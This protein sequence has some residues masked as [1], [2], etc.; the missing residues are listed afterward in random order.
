MTRYRKQVSSH[1]RMT[2][3]RHLAKGIDAE[4]LLWTPF[5]IVGVRA[6]R[7]FGVQTGDAPRT[8]LV[9]TPVTRARTWRRSPMPS[10]AM[11]LRLRRTFGSG[12]SKGEQGLE[13]LKEDLLRPGCS[14]GV[15]PM[16]GQR[17]GT[18]DR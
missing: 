10:S 1:E 15:K 11:R 7:S 17:R 13:D 14:H 4:V 18:G 2:C 9:G 6:R 16:R 8:P 12:I 3:R 5:V